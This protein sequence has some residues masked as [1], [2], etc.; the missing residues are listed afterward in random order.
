MLRFGLLLT[1][2]LL[3][4]VG[5]APSV[6]LGQD[7][8]PLSSREAE[9]TMAQFSQCIVRTASRQ[10]LRRFLRLIP[11]SP[12]FQTAGRRLVDSYCVPRVPGAVMRMRFRFDLL[13]SALYS[14]L[15]RRDFRTSGPSDLGNLPPLLLSTEFDG[16]PVEIP[17]ATRA[18][19]S[20]GDCTVRL[21][22]P[23]AH[24][25]LMTDVGSSEE[26]RAITA[27]LPAMQRCMTEAQQLRFSRGMLRGILAEALYKLRAASAPATEA[28]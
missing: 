14:A 28:G 21:D 20:L 5:T 11:G 1:S 19:R 17:A 9:R 8:T 24:A 16:P 4:S 25:L 10:T 22:A 6:A 27:S 7:S 18:L 12:A 26:Q 3:A 13:R 23:A 2:M 15:Y